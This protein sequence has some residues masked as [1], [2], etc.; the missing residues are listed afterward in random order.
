MRILL[1]GGSGFIGTTLARALV[2]RGHQVTVLSRSGQGTEPRVSYLRGNVATGEGLEQACAN[3]DAVVYL[4]GIIR[5]RGGQTF[6]LAHLEGVRHTIAAM[7]A[8]GVRRLVH[9]SALG[10][11]LGTGSRYFETKAL[12]EQAVLASGLEAVV[13]RPSLVF[14]PGDDFF[15]G[16]LRGLVTAPAPFIPM[17]GDGHFPFRPIWVGDVAQAFAQALEAPKPDPTPCNL[18]GP[19]EYTFRQ[20]LL[21][22]RQVLGSRKPLLPLPI[23]LMDLL[24][25]LLNLLPFSPLTLDQ[26]RMLKAGNTADPAPMLARFQLELRPLEAELPQI[27]KKTLPVRV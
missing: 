4:V 8:Q 6:Q 23:A 21:A 24:V 12:A 25:P 1:A 10:A 27:L 3:Q 15:G 5:E 7:Q 18:V 16:V 9:M 20:L 14:G 13:L 19:T 26:Y 22:V 11:A 2:A 17:I